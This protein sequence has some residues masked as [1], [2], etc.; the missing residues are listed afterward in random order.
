MG[1]RFQKGHFFDACDLDCIRGQMRLTG[2]FCHLGQQFCCLHDVEQFNR[3]WKCCVGSKI[4]PF[5]LGKFGEDMGR[6]I[7]F[8]S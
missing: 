8:V 4:D 6:R 3:L 7:S 2:F 5:M 1:G